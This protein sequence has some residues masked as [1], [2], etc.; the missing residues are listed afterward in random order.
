MTE[1][2]PFI[3]VMIPHLNQSEALGRCLQSLVEQSYPRELFEVI[4]VDNGSET[5]P[6]SIVGRFEGACLATEQRP[7]PGPARNRGV[8]ASRGEI[9]AFIDADCIADSGWLGA[10]ARTLQRPEAKVI[11]GGDVRIAVRDT[12]RLTAIEAYESVFAFRQKEYIEKQGFSGTGNLAVRR[13]DFDAIGPFAGIKVAEDMEW[14]RRATERGYHIRHTPEMIVSHP[15]RRN[16]TEL[17]AK[18][19]RHIRHDFRQRQI[20]GLGRLTWC[21]RALAVAV[22]AIVHIP[23]IANSQRISGFRERLMAMLV[24]MHIRAYRGIRML[25]MA[26]HPRSK[27]EEIRWNVLRGP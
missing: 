19:D 5:P 25:S 24:L 26:V 15:A 21:L 20:D 16:F 9:V 7:G 17:C 12:R 4:V 27:N 10:I 1:S 14:G 8:E 11:A 6:T 18:W 22:S 23:K 3:S 2:L 13:D